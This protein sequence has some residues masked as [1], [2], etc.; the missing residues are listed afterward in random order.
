MVYGIAIPTF[1]GT[2][3]PHSLFRQEAGIDA[4]FSEIGAA[5]QETIEPMSKCSINSEAGLE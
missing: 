5:I 4:R 1:V 2:T 3:N